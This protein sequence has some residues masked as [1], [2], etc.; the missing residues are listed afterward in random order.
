MEYY[1]KYFSGDR[2]AG[3]N[4]IILDECRP[5]YAK[6]RVI[7]DK[8][9]LNGAGVL[10]GGL[11][12]TLAD[13]AFAAATNSYGN[14]ALSINAS[15]NYF[16]KCNQGVIIAEAKEIARSNKLITCDI[17][18]E[19]EGG[20]LLANFKGTAYITKQAIDFK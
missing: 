18:V 13:F 8:R 11:I 16:D 2:F 17:T 4:G 7:V 5:G 12:F 10:H 15:I 9:H 19:Q 1:K 20:P 6:V 14:I 3:E